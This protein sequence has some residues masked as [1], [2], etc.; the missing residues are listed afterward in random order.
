MQNFYQEDLAYVHSKGYSNYAKEAAEL[1]LSK[2]EHNHLK[3]GKIVDLGCGGGQLLAEVEPHNYETIGVEYSKDIIEIARQNAPR[4]TFYHASIW[5]YDLPESVAITAIGEILTY[6]FDQKN[7]L[8]NI[9]LLFEMIYQQLV[10]NGIFLFDVLTPQAATQS[11]DY[12]IVKNEEWTMNLEYH[13]NLQQQT[14][15]RDITLFR[16]VENGLYRKS[17]EVHSVRLLA[18]ERLMNMLEKI[19]FKCH[20]LS[21]YGASNFRL[22]HIGVL[23]QK[24]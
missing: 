12:K 8:E 5:D 10:P 11:Y 6:A 4:S 9:R 23:A 14:L 17:H 20:Q 13:Y 7:S 3:T 2:L 16:Q 15:L 22:G 18:I 21:S 1:L 19:G 24:L